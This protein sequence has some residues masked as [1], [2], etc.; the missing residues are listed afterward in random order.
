MIYSQVKVGLDTVVLK[1]AVTYDLIDVWDKYVQ[2]NYWMQNI[3][4]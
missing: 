2:Q 3:K 4:S 1:A